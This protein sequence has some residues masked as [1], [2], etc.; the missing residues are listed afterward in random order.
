MTAQINQCRDCQP[1]DHWLEIRLVDEMN[2]PFGS[3]HGQLKD[4]SGTEHQVMLSGGYLLLTELPAGPVELKMDTPALLNEAQKHQPRPA[5]QISPAKEYAETHKGYKKSKIK[6]QNI[7]LGDVWYL[8]PEII[9]ERHKAGQTGKSLRMVSNNS[10][11]LEVRSL[12]DL[13]LPQVIF[14]SQHPMD[15]MTADDMQSGDMSKEEIMNLGMFKPF[16]KLRYEFELPASDHFTNFRL[17][18]G[19]VS[20]GEY[21]P[22]TKMMIDRFEQNTGNKFTHFLLN[23]AA[24]EHENTKKVVKHIQNAFSEKINEKCGELTEDDLKG[25]WYELAHGK[26]IIHLPGFDTWPDWFNGLGITVH[27]IWSLQLSLKEMQIDIISRTFN[28]VVSFKAQD[29]FGLNVDDIDGHKYFEFLRIFRAWFILQRYK[30]FGYKPFIT[31]MNHVQNIS[32]KF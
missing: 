5:P 13:H 17:F 27:G 20:S 7:T 16:S 4:A 32:G 31:E 1:K 14:Q 21:S 15:D 26:H 25:I 3:L 9:P 29:H 24:S 18:A 6:F 30:K 22:L 28:G 10:Y 12:S 19:L 23:K 2:H 11:L 8:E